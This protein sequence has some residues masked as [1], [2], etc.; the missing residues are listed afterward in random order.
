MRAPTPHVERGLPSEGARRPEAVHGGG[1]TP[2]DRQVHH[3]LEGHQLHRV[4]PPVVDG[5][6]AGLGL[7]PLRTVNTKNQ[8]SENTKNRTQRTLRTE[9]SEL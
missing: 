6:S 4:E 2:V 1:E 9:I 7:E 5:L 3:L 8:N